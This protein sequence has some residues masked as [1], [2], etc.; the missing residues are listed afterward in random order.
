MPHP[1]CLTPVICRS[2]PQGWRD[3][4]QQPAPAAA[5]S[6]RPVTAL[7]VLGL[8]A[9]GG[10]SRRHLS[11]A[12]TVCVWVC[13]CGLRAFCHSVSF[14]LLSSKPS[15][16]CVFCEKIE[17]LHNSQ[18]YVCSVHGLVEI[19]SCLIPDALGRGW[20]DQQSQRGGPSWCWRARRVVGETALVS[21]MLCDSH[22]ES[23]FLRL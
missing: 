9:F 22:S 21:A 15:C 23:Q 4:G 11:M 7:L 12:V 6:G 5:G 13:P 2:L 8:K 1:F 10:G 17:P 14:I 18:V 20:L 19:H 3:P 16:L